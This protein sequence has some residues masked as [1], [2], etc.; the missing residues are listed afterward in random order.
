MGAPSAAAGASA[1]PSIILP[2]PGRLAPLD[3]LRGLAVLAVVILHFYVAPPVLDTD[4][5]HHLFQRLFSLSFLG[6]DLFFVL[7]GFLIGGILL[8]H[9]SAPNLLPVFYARRFFRIIPIYLL[10]LATFLVGRNVPGLSAVNY[11]TYF[12]ST[13]PIWPYFTFTQNIFMALHRDIGPYWLGPTWSL[14][15]EEQFYL[16]IPLLV[17][18]L[19]GRQLALACVAL[20][21]VAPPLRLTAVLRAENNLAAI[22]LLPTR[23]DALP[24]GILCAL[25]VREAR[26]RDW[27][28]AHRRFFAGTIAVGL[29]GLVGLSLQNYEAASWQICAFGYTTCNVVFAALLL[30]VVVL[31]DSRPA[32]MLSLPW[33]CGLGLISYFVYLFHTP[34]L[35]FLHWVF[36]NRPP[37]HWTGQAWAVTWL[38]AVVTLAL[39]WFSWRFLE[40]PLLSLARRSNYR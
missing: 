30:Y 18:R 36:L 4:R 23:A 39:G 28:L 6:V 8:D 20:I 2:S 24:W 10:L 9:R 7:S 1:P 21:L 13:V 29:I 32:R 19:T 12:W 26:C 35:Y 22:F 33:L 37:L 38:S 16:V 17:Q 3:G 25:F 40:G 15:I 5:V 27:L 31:P 11:G 34:V 14:A